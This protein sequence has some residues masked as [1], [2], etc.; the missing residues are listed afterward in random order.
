MKTSAGTRLLSRH[1]SIVLLLTLSPVLGWGQAAPSAEIYSCVDA[2]GHR[3]T[4]DRK[5]PSC[6]DREQRVLNP[7]GTVK[8]TVG[9]TLTAQEKNQQEAKEKLAAQERARLDEEKKR[10][11][12]L[13]IRYPNEALHQKERAE[14]LAQIALVKQAATVRAAELQVEYAKLQDE[15]AFYAKDPKRAPTKLR[16]QLNAAKLAADGQDHFIAD[17]DLETA[18]TNARFDEELQR[19]RPLW[20][21]NAVSATQ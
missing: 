20:R 18:R 16:L 12:A 6:D 9:P 8:A 7:S 13:L 11:R 2:K 14:A 15:M 3:I 1:G 17:K 19:L 21:M 5:I 4:S 10:D